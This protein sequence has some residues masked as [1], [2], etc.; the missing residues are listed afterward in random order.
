M[1]LDET[2]H[3]SDEIVAIG[4]GYEYDSRSRY[5]WLR[6]CM[7]QLRSLQL[8]QNIQ[9]SLEIVAI[10]SGYVCIS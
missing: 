8:A 7:F 9:V 5:Y 4:S 10:G 1:Q 2:M 6:L 3:I